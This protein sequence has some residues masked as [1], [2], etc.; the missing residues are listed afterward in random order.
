MIVG[1]FTEFLYCHTCLANSTIM[2]K[3]VH[4]YPP[5]VWLF[6]STDCVISILQSNVCIMNCCVNSELH[7]EEDYSSEV[8][9]VT[10]ALDCQSIKYWVISRWSLYLNYALTI[11]LTTGFKW[12]TVD[13][14]EYFVKKKKVL[15]APIANYNGT[16]EQIP[17][18]ANAVFIFEQDSMQ[19]TTEYS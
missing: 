7:W 9:V 16:N 2:C 15:G 1:L 11:Q 10:V 14:S 12:K 19:H 3:T 5:T 6:L 8:H 17:A 18:N 4:L 13:G